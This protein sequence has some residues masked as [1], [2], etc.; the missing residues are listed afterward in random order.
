MQR[1]ADYGAASLDEVLLDP[2]MADDD[3]ANEVINVV[4]RWW[5]ALRDCKN[6]VDLPAFV[7]MNDA[8]ARITGA[9]MRA[10]TR[11][12]LEPLDLAPLGRDEVLVAQERQYLQQLDSS[13]PEGE[14]ELF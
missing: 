2:V 14:I 4:Y 13:P 11:L 1:V 7:A 6:D 3:R 8:P 12:G 10:P 5:T 9:V